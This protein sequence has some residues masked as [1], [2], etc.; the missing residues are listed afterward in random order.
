MTNTISDRVFNATDAKGGCDIVPQKSACV[1]IEYQNEFTS[2]G[3]KMYDAVLNVMQKT[4]MLE[5]SVEVAKKA[6]E[7]GM[8]VIHAPI[9]FKADSSDNPNSK[10][11]ILAGCKDGSLFTENTWNADF[12]EKMKP[13]ENDLV[14]KGKKGLDAFTNTNLENLL[15]SNDIETVILGGFL[16]NC[17]VE[18]TMYVFILNFNFFL[19]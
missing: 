17:C 4:N 19:Y 5:N 3:G 14:V 13:D 9:M 18:S 12:Y 2:K 8:L 6:R 7:C 11:G 1:F 16:T 15:I 10:L